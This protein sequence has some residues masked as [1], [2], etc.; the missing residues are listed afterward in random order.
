M[1][2]RADMK[3]EVEQVSHVPPSLHIPPEDTHELG[4]RA[5]ACSEGETDAKYKLPAVIVKII[6]VFDTTFL[7]GIL[8]AFLYEH[9]CVH[10]QVLKIEPKSIK[11]WSGKEECPLWSLTLIVGVMLCMTIG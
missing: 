10:T 9:P 7:P 3:T 6:L 11:I 4:V 8:A 1:K 2:A 5:R